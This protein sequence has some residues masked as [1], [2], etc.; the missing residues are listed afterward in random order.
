MVV[1]VSDRGWG[2]QHQMTP[3]FIS[4]HGHSATRPLVEPFQRD[5]D[6]SEMQTRGWEKKWEQIGGGGEGCGRAR[7]GRPPFWII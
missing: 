4:S 6:P 3:V 5:L 2:L 1:V 7:W